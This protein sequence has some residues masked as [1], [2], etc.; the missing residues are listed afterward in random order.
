MIKAVIFDMYETLITHFQSPLYFS[1]QMAFDAGMTEH[2]FQALWEPTESDRTIGNLTFE[3]VLETI[4]KENGHYSKEL[5]HNIVQKRIQTKEEC[6]NHLHQEIL[7]LLR[8]LKQNGIAIGLI[9]NCFSEEAAVIRR[10][11]LFPY[12]DAVCLSY[13]EGIKKPDTKIYARCLEKL[14]VGADECLYVGDGGSFELEAADK[15]GMHTAQAVWYLQDGIGQPVGRK[16]DFLQL[17]TPMKVL[18]YILEKR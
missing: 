18:D 10:S 17:E 1:A 9:S 13:E 5:F 12:F 2:Q 3:E 11:V 8:G 6:F 15:I 4:L 14:Y 16:A 7:P